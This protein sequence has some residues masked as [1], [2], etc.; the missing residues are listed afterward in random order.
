[1][2]KLAEYIN[3]SK[4]HNSQKTTLDGKPCM[5]RTAQRCKSPYQ[6]NKK[7]TKNTKNNKLKERIKTGFLLLCR[8]HRRLGYGRK[9]SFLYT[10]FWSPTLFQMFC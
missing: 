5:Q 3:T 10:L 1:M 6:K 8:L 4:K 7:S 9:R 2:T